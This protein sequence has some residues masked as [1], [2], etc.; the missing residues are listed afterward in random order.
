MTK[1]AGLRRSEGIERAGCT[2]FVKPRRRQAAV[3]LFLTNKINIPQPRVGLLQVVGHQFHDV[4]GNELLVSVSWA[5]TEEP[6]SIS[7][8]FSVL[9]S[10]TRLDGLISP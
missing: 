2:L 4:G 1:S 5:N 7:A 3:E 9:A 8:M 10:N 6:Q